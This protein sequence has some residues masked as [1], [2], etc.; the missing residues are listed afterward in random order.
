MDT[1]QHCTRLQEQIEFRLF[2][3]CI[4]LRLTYAKD[5]TMWTS[6]QNLFLVVKSITAPSDHIQF[7]LQVKVPGNGKKRKHAASS[8][9]VSLS[10]C[11]DC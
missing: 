4:Q 2:P 7:L 5:P 1:M 3:P 11:K 6:K 10:R 8:C 9:M